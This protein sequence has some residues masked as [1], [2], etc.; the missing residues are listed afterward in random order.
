[1]KNNG[2]PPSKLTNQNGE[3]NINLE[4]LNIIVHRCWL[5]RQKQQL[6]RGGTEENTSSG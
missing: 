6:N 1:M 5:N 3:N 2:N 4:G